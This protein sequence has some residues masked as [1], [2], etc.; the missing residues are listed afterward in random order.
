MKP[1]GPVTYASSPAARSSP[2]TW[3]RTSSESDSRTDSSSTVSV[4]ES[5]SSGAMTRKASPS[6]LGMTARGASGG[7]AR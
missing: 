3:V 6:P 1:A 4:T 2:S 5:A 7:W